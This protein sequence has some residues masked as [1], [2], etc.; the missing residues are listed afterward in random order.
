MSTG[1]NVIYDSHT[2]RVVVFEENGYWAIPSHLNLAHYENGSEP[3]LIHDDNGAVY[4]RPN[5]VIVNGL[6]DEG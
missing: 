5:T 2:K 1:I 4:L 6:F 3:V